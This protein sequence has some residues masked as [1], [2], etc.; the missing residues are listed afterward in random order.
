M[1]I[2]SG[3]GTQTD[4]NM[5][6]QYLISKIQSAI[7]CILQLGG[8]FLQSTELKRCAALALHQGTKEGVK[9]FW[10]ILSIEIDSTLKPLFTKW[11]DLEEKI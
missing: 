3:P 4:H 7:I 10:E 6:S 11:Y 9:N 1:V 8:P 5:T 2:P